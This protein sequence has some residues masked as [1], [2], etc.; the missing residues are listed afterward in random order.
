MT[1]GIE[2]ILIQLLVSDAQHQG[3]TGEVQLPKNHLSWQGSFCRAKL[4][5]EAPLRQDAE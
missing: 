5:S 2:K 3:L 1:E 4:M